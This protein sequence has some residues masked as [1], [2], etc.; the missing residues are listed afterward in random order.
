MRCLHPP[1]PSPSPPPPRCRYSNRIANGTFSL[2]G[3]TYNTPINEPYVG[4]GGDTLHGGTVG[5]DRRLWDVVAL[6]A[7]SV[8]L[9]YVSPDGEMGFPSA[10]NVTVTH[11]LT[12]QGYWTLQYTAVNTGDVDTVVALTNH[13]YWNLGAFAFSDTVLDHRLQMDADTYLQVWDAGGGGGGCWPACD[14]WRR[15]V[16]TSHPPPPTAAVSG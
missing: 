12:P 16:P 4:G 11:T 13:A 3:A 9:A 10:L 2:N 5:Y 14:L 6:N 7:S 1:P 8:T 15:R